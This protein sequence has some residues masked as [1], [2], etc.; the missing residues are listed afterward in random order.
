MPDSVPRDQQRQKMKYIGN[1]AQYDE[2][3]LMRKYPFMRKL[4]SDPYDAVRKG[5]RT[6][7]AKL[8]WSYFQY[9]LQIQRPRFKGSLLLVISRIQSN[10]LEVELGYSNASPP[11]VGLLPI[12]PRPMGNHPPVSTAVVMSIVHQRPH[13]NGHDGRRWQPLRLSEQLQSTFRGYSPPPIFQLPGTVQNLCIKALPDTGSSQ[14][15]KDSSPIST[16]S[17]I[18]L[19]KL[20]GLFL[21]LFGSHFR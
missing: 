19:R 12:R 18:L 1:M 14:N 5:F 3:D 7:G 9:R 6:M 21:P 16:Q 20:Q 4:S 10:R 2:S 17:Y 8:R 15:V 13:Y 11:P